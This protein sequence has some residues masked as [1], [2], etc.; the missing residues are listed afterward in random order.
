MVNA[1]TGADEI[2]SFENS[3]AQL[4]ERLFARV[5]PAPA[6]TPRLLQLNRPLAEELRLDAD[7][8]ASA[9]GVEILSGHSVV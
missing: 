5:T 3:F 7:R 2:F 1:T 9:E 6:P 8:L 4:P